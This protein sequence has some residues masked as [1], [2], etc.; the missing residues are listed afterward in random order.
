[1]EGCCGAA[2]W[3]AVAL[4]MLLM[5]LPEAVAPVTGALLGV[6]RGAAGC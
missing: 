3:G 2:A 1:M 5:V 6:A 4:L